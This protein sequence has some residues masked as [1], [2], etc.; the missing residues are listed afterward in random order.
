MN[1][2]LY[3]DESGVLDP[4]HHEFYTFG[5]LVFFSKADCETCARKYIAAERNVRKS[6][7]I[8]PD[9]EVK[10][11]GIRPG[12]KRKLFAVASAGETFGAVISQRK[13]DE[14]A[15]FENKKTKQRYLDWVYTRTVVQKFRD[16]IAR[17]VLNPRYV[18]AVTFEVDEHTTATDG[19]YEL[20]ELLE[21]ELRAG[22]WDFESFTRRD[23]ILPYVR[24]VQL[25]Y[26]NSASKTLVR[27]ADIVSNHLYYC[28]NARAP[29]PTCSGRM[30]IFRHPFE[31]ER[32]ENEE[33]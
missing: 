25:R 27:A 28:A 32:E 19:R 10:A 5:G 6:E 21:I 30:S 8:A 2:F 13:I 7:N 26:Y 22:S 17:G 4:V 16:M 24:S 14:E 11:S 20:S 31:E 9:K 12:N 3:S 29:F 33:S 18:D 15:L 23:P 1:V